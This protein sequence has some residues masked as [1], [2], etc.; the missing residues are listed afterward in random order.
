ME[1]ETTLLEPGALGTPATDGDSVY[2]VVNQWDLWE[3][4][5]VASVDPNTG[6]VEWSVNTTDV[7]L[8]DEQFV[9]F[10]RPTVHG[11]HVL[12]GEE[13]GSLYAFD[14][15]SGGLEWEVDATS[16][17]VMATA[18]T[19]ETLYGCSGVYHHATDSLFCFKG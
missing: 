9:G 14:T 7:G 11:G 15:G 6:E 18:T 8:D 16:V 17:D 1:W 19:G 12:V 3:E 13:N 5:R 2:A 4:S 10:M